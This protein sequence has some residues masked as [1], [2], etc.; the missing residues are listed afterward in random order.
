M[1]GPQPRDVGLELAQ[2]LGAD[3]LGVGNAVRERP[4][5]ELL[6]ARELGDARRDDDLPATED[7]NPALVAVR[8]QPFRA[9]HA[10]P[11]LERAGRVVDAA[12]DDTR[13]MAGLVT[14][15]RGLLVEDGEPEPRTAG[16]Q[17]ARK[18]EAEDAC[19]DDGDVVTRH[20]SGFLAEARHRGNSTPCL[21]SAR[22][23][24]FQGTLRSACTRGRTRPRAGST[25]RPWR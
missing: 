6:E 18:G 13:R 8:E 12:V 4:P 9:L 3:Q 25:G 10:E 14:R 17:L 21:P 20:Q 16:L 2:P 11:R 19:A 24:L 23:V 7:G 22:H 15:D 5:L 1:E